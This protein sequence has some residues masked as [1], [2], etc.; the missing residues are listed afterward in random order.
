M[1]STAEKATIL[2]LDIL[3]TVGTIQPE[4]LLSD[5]KV[6]RLRLG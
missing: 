3:A 5:Q 1:R 2:L 6:K 4:E